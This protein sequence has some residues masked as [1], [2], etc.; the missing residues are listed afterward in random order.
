L[1]EVTTTQPGW[2]YPTAL[3]AVDGAGPLTRIEVAQISASF[4]A[5]PAR[6]RALTLG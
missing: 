5:G 4:G 6:A 3:Q 1:R 2:T